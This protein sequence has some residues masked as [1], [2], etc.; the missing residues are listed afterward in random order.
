VFPEFEAANVV[1]RQN[2][3]GGAAGRCDA[4]DAHTAKGEVLAP[5]LA[6]RVK[7]SRHL[8]GLGINSCQVRPFVQVAAMAGQSQIIRIVGAAMLFRDYVLD[9]VG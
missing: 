6:A 3:N 1:H 8:S 7:E 4:L 2:K 9:V 5:L